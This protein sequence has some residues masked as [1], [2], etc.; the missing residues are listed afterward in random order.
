[1]I[2]N[3]CKD[4]VGKARDFVNNED[5]SGDVIKSL[6]WT[7]DQIPIDA[8]KTTCEK[9]VDDNV[10]EILKML[11][12]SMDP[13]AVCS[14]LFFCNNARFDD[15][16][17][18]NS[19][20]KLLPFTC[21]QC[22]YITSIVEKKF[23]DAER[24]DVL[25]GL[26]GVCGELSSYSDSCS[27][28]VM[29]HFDDIY[30]A[31]GNNVV[32]EKLCDLT[33]ACDQ[34]QRE[35]IVDIMPANDLVGNDIPCQLCEQTV[36]HLREVLIAN[37]TDIEFRNIM[38]GFC[39]QLGKFSDECLTISNQYYLSIYNFL[40]DKL[41]ANKACI[42]IGICPQKGNKLMMPMM[43]LVS[44]ELHPTPEQPQHHAANLIKLGTTFDESSLVLY[45]NGSWCTTCSLLV[46]FLQEALAKQSTQDDIVNVMKNTCQKLPTTVQKEC[47]ALI[48]LYG[49]AMMSFLDQ[50]L[51]PR[52]ICPKIKL[53]P[54]YLDLKL[55]QETAI[56]DKPTCPFCLFA[57]QEVR[58]VIASNNTK[59]NIENV[60]SKL[61][62]H[63][64]D[65]LLSQCTEF[66]KK[67]S[68]EVVEM[69]LADFTPQEACTFIKLCTDNKVEYQNSK[70][71]R[72][73]DDF[74]DEFEELENLN[75]PQCELCK[76]IVKIV[77][78]RVINKKSKDEI[79]REL[80]KSCD[81]LKKFAD[82]CKTFVDKYSDKIVELIEQELEP[83]EV[84]REL[85]FCVNIHDVD[86]QDYDSGLD[87]LV[88]ATKEVEVEIKAQPQ[89]VICEFVMTKL[90]D[91][92]NDKKTDDEIKNAVRNVCAKMPATV[93]KSCKQF[94]D[95]YFD[96]IIVF[97]ETM[98][99][100]EVCGEMKLCPAP[101]YQEV[102][103]DLQHDIF[104]CALCKGLVEGIDA[105]IEDPYT[106]TNLE[107]LEEKLCE[108]FAG[109]YRPKVCDF[110][111]IKFY[112]FS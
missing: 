33:R 77:E 111:I 99:P 31:I 96:M 72:I 3:D 62:N 18:K 39:R 42:Q 106:D 20:E 86:S 107:N 67:Y 15:I 79:R 102:I 80:E 30:N 104:K 29:M 69:V 14:K 17:K 44:A 81:R 83:Q 59:Q 6:K 74:D 24:D 13:D 60:V 78:Q 28:I 5:K 110:K 71:V 64:S 1:M 25:E 10:P 21:G 109:K 65:K 87:I 73:V 108:K 46:H 98:K 23:N 94:V 22:Q 50:D 41:S 95:Y 47:V 34:R 27:S 52:L 57:M 2:C 12:S 63:L 103:E 40:L 101:S 49:D 70:I 90:E 93:A 58:D 88:T 38:N 43:P 11:E 97:I 55:L 91:E 48:E 19:K 76:E 112:L 66:V 9:I 53:C 100:S 8:L 56:D 75:N 16:L 7:C 68:D 26:L 36:L 105:V 82:K 32:S 85:V 54:P 61:C 89:C 45:K 4:W 51:D 84:C 37:T 92:L 35:G